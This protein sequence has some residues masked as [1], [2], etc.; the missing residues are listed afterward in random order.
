MSDL[1]QMIEK[2]EEWMLIHGEDDELRLV[3]CF[4][5]IANHTYGRFL[6]KVA[7]DGFQEFDMS[8]DRPL[9]QGNTPEILIN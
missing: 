6:L 1:Q 5:E 4:L 9:D 7:K 3:M 2:L 8:R